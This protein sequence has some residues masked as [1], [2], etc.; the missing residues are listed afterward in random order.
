MPGPARE[1][2][3]RGALGCARGGRGRARAA[4]SILVIAYHMLRNGVDF[5]D[6][7]ADI[8]TG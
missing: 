3:E 7:G 5:N 8:S 2:G 6:L 1:W 4:H